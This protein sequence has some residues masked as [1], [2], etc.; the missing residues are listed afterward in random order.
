MRQCSEARTPPA[1]DLEAAAGEHAGGAG[2]RPG[3]AGR[4]DTLAAPGLL[5]VWPPAPRPLAGTPACRGRTHL[6]KVGARGPRLPPI[7]WHARP[8]GPESS[9]CGCARCGRYASARV[10]PR[11]RGDGPIAVGI[12][13][14]ETLGLGSPPRPRPP[15]PRPR[16]SALRRGPAIAPSVRVNLR[17][18]DPA[19]PGRFLGIGVWEWGRPAAVAPQPPSAQ[20]ER[21][22]VTMRPRP[23]VRMPGQRLLVT[24]IPHA[25]NGEAAAGGGG[26]GARRGLGSPRS[27][28]RAETSWS[29]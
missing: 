26:A 8:G 29:G 1:P 22:V 3:R 15:P 12:E 9:E 24:V 13:A 6:S 23:G 10:W 20:M 18:T 2:R 21:M 28:A 17:H 16:A 11:V 5:P 27:A 4:A 19:R 25:A 14:T 7:S